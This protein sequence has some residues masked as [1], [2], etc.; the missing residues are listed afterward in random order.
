MYAIRSYYESGLEL[1]GAEFKPVGNDIKSRLGI[2]YGLQV[3]SLSE[4]KLQD[5]GVRPGYIIVK[6]NDYKITSIDDL[7]KALQN[8]DGGLFIS[9]I[10]PNG[11]TGY[12][13]IDPEE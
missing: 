8:I 7:K 10:Y 1:L 9:G 12:L 4:G 3:T 13:A 11:R 2:G 5:A 6:I